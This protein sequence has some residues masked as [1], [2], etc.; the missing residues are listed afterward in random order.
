MKNAARTAML[1]AIFTL[2][3]KILGFVREMVMANYYGTSYVTGAYVMSTTV[4]TML[5]GGLLT[6]VAT[7]FIP[8]YSK[9][10]ESESLQSANL[11][12]SQTINILLVISIFSSIIGFLFSDQLVCIFASGYSGEVAELTSYYLKVTMSMILFTSITGI[13]ESYLKY[14]NIF[15]ISIIISYLVNVFSIITVILSIQYG[16]H[17]I[18]YGVLIGNGLRFIIMAVIAKAKKYNYKFNF[19]F[20]TTAKDIFK[21]SIPVFIGTTVA[22]INTYVDR[23]LATHLNFRSVPA[24]NFG[25]LVVTLITG[26]F[27]TVITTMLYPK[28][29]RAYSQ[30][31]EDKFKTLFELGLN[32]LIIIGIPFALGALLYSEDIIQIIYERGVFDNASTQYTT[33]AFFYYSPCILFSTLEVFLIQTFYSM[34][35]VKTPLKFALIG[36]A[37]NITANLIL[38][39]YL[40]HGGLALGTSIASATVVILLL[41]SIKKRYPQ[42]LP[43]EIVKTTFKILVASI[44]AVALSFAVYYFIKLNIWMPRTVLMFIVIV[45]ASI[46]YLVSLKVLQ[47]KELSYLKDIFKQ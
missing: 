28:M 5:L 41:S 32:L 4:P 23:T 16:N 21:F 26:V 17:I 9:K 31:D 39:N 33:T 24:L 25:N 40:E 13:Y 8:L 14:H 20:K 47:I 35:N 7:S 29:A 27:S 2:G 44:V 42:L 10:R 37:I 22:Q 15:N 1:M 45:F 38:V 46:I 6:A 12:M 43:T 30:N 18:V 3:S 36:I 34:H 11:F 19:H